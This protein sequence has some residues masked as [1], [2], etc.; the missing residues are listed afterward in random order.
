MKSP[1]EVLQSAAKRSATYADASGN[2]AGL[3][4]AIIYSLAGTGINS[5]NGDDVPA[6]TVVWMSHGDRVYDPGGA[7]IS[8]AETATCP[9]AAVRHR[10]R[11]VFGLQFHPEV[12]H[13]AYGTL[14]LGNFLDRCAISLP[15]HA[16]GELPVG[17]MLMAETM[18]DARLLG[19][20]RSVAPA[21]VAG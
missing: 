8:L 19:I 13:T 17:F 2:Y 3:A 16:A 5:Y 10:D 4:S 14:I 15:C 9:V 7:F 20:S 11:P 6:S 12:A 18:T 21:V 1:A